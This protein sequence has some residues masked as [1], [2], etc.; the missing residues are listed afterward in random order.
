MITGRYDAI[1][2]PEEQMAAHELIKDS[3][4]LILPNC[5]HESFLDQPEMLNK[6]IL[7]YLN[8]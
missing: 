7:N 6:A 8:L 3:K 4:L 5:A 2:T 1:A